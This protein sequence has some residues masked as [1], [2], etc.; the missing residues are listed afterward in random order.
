[1]VLWYWYYMVWYYMGWYYG[2]AYIVCNIY[3]V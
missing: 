2:I 1:M 3:I